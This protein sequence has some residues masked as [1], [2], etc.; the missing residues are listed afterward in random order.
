LQDYLSAYCLG[1]LNRSNEAA[2]MQ[3]EVLKFTEK[4]Y[5]NPSVNNLMALLVYQSK[6]ETD[7]AE[8]LIQEITSSTHGDHFLNKW[9]I[10]TFRKD[11]AVS[12]KLE[13]EFDRDSYMPIVKAIAEL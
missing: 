11:T 8:K 4:N 12:S 6:G 13:K 2:G 9:V 3:A 1:K 7:K 5:K 10:A